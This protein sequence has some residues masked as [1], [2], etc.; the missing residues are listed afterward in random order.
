MGR[1]IAIYSN[2]GGVGKTTT[3]VNLT[4]CLAL[5]GNRVLLADL[6]PRGLA[7]HRLASA[8]RNGRDTCNVLL[9]PEQLE[10]AVLP[11][12]FPN[13]SVLPSCP[14]LDDIEESLVGDEKRYFKFRD[15]L[16][17]VQEHYDFVIVDC[18][19]RLGVLTRNALAAADGTILPVQCEPYALEGLAD[20]LKDIHD[21]RAVHHPDLDLD[22]VLLTLL[23]PDNPLSLDVARQVQQREDCRVFQSVVPRD[24][25]VVAAAQG[26]TPLVEMDMGSRAARAYVELTREVLNDAG[27]QAG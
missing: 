10:D 23:D 15:A 26:G 8:S 9:R 18:A 11:A 5:A 3:A 14:T 4:A 1:T 22:G 6:D 20:L 16:T 12:D 7:C 24:P 27:T 17:L 21:F 2:K 19:P 25:A 13:V